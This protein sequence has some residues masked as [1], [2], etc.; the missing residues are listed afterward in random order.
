MQHTTHLPQLL[1]PAFQAFEASGLGF[2]SQLE[3]LGSDGSWSIPR[4]ATYE[5][6]SRNRN[7][8]RSRNRNRDRNRNRNRNSS[9]NTNT[10]GHVSYQDPTNQDPLKL[11]SENAALRS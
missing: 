11:N 6:V 3:A 5:V 2:A 10:Y 4:S 7:R 8:S 1:L 9:D